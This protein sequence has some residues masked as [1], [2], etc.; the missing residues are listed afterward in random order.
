MD[1]ACRLLAAAKD[2]PAAKQVADKAHALEIYARRQ[3]LG[4]EAIGYAHALKVDAMACLG[5]FLKATP[6]NRGAVGSCVSGSRREPVK[7]D[8]ETLASAGISKKE[9]T[10]AQALADVQATAPDLF[11][12]IKSRRKRIVDAVR[13]VHNNK[14]AAE[15]NSHAA[16]E[17]PDAKIICGDGIAGL[18]EHRGK[19]RLITADSVYNV[20]I[21]YGDGAK[22]D[23]LPDHVYLDWC[24]TWME[25]ARDVLTPD[26]SLWVLICNEYADEFGCAL[27]RIGLTIR[28]WITWYE[29]FGVNCSNSFNRCSRRLF[30]CVKNPKRFVFNAEAVTRQSD[31]QAKYN[32]KR[33]NPGGKIMDDVWL[34]PRL[35]GTC[36]ERIP[37]FPT[38]LPMALLRPIVGCA[39]DP[40]DLVI[41]PFCGSGTTGA[42]CIESSRRFIGFEKQERFADLARK[43][44]AKT[45]RKE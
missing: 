16:V 12:E 40:G 24:R 45:K 6:K 21:D 11:A 7:D 34:I 5:A 29:T 13:H 23:R 25:A 35:T 26:G 38:Q 10:A 15:L 14:K 2:A 42:V 17:S 36:K 20:G 1:A 44:L 33:A 22:A 30:Y 19:A 18:K 39:S 8:R 32:D 4:E 41:D 3:K 43:R 9:S 31:R 27:K 28:S 37:G